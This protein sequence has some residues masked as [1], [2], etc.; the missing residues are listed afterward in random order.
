MWS[1]Q[2]GYKPSQAINWTA[3]PNA[4]GYKLQWRQHPAK[5]TTLDPRLITITSD[6]CNDD[7]H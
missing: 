3:A 5:A 1:I 6:S 2:P 7:V 4:T